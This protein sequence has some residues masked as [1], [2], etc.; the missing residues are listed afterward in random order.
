MVGNMSPR[1]APR[2]VLNI[3]RHLSS[4]IY[5]HIPHPVSLWATLDATIQK[6]ERNRPT[7]Y[8]RLPQNIKG[9][10]SIMDRYY[11]TEQT[12]RPLRH[13][14]PEEKDKHV[15]GLTQLDPQIARALL[16]LVV[17]SRVQ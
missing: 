17:A 9:E 14:S 3:G 11:S 7:R 16:A 6:N 15:L 1:S 5:H 8:Y 12:L 4:L 13:L 10:G 2:D